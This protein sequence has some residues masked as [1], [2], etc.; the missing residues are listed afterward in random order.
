MLGEAGP[1]AVVDAAA[2]PPPPR[3]GF[4][5]RP[6]FNGDADAAFWAEAR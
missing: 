3:S 4:A 6:K 1:A 2:L 5:I